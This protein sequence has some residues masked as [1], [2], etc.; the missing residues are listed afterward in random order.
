MA[1]DVTIAGASYTGVPA[2]ELPT[3][4]GGTAVFPDTSDATATAAQLASGAT[5]Y[6]G[7][8]KLTGTAD[9][10]QSSSLA[11]SEASATATASY[12]SGDFLMLGGQ[13]YKATAAIAV[14]DALVVG[15]NIVATTVAEQIT[16]LW[17]TVKSFHHV[18]GAE[19]DGSDSTAWTRTDDAAWFTDPIPYVAGATSYGSPFDNLMP[20]AGMVRVIDSEAGEMVK[21]PKFWYKLTQ[22]AS[23][24][25]KIQISTG[26]LDGYSVC[27]A[28]MD[29]GDGNGERDYVL[30]GRY[31]CANN[32]YKS[33]SGA[34][35]QV[36]IT[37]PTARSNVAALGSDV[38]MMDWA[39][40]FT[41]WLLYLVEFADWNS[42]A[43]IGYGCG[44]GSATAAMG[45]TDSMP[46][47]TGTTQSSRTT[48]GLGTQYRYIEGLWDNVR[49]WVDGAYNG[50]SGLMLILDPSSG[51]DSS[52]G[53]SIG[54]PSSGWPSVFTVKDISGTFPLFVPTMSGGSESTYSCDVWY[55]DASSP[56][57][58]S[59]GYY[60]NNTNFGMFFYNYMSAS[61]SNGSI[62]TR[63]MKLP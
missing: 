45:Y 30:V 28:C 51:S 53:V 18:Y 11:P 23:G 52:G 10:A 20:W 36:N 38:W 26:E 32:T 54:T 22:G 34:V 9:Y 21:I 39:L 47:H 63:P 17:S 19:W 50:S 14:G 25:F 15:T 12:S 27:P 33:T 40:R 37:R 16:A 57:I 46:Y 41:I 61:N 58:N 31:H 4:T 44:D 6:V 7:G 60:Q 62:G 48:Y 3:A 55:Y 8:A 2:V 56:C 42:Q 5:A 24:G 1:Q 49:D 59:G 13:L 29:R 43:C 35:P